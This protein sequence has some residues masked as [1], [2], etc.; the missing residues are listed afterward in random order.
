[1]SASITMTTRRTRATGSLILFG[2]AAGVAL[3]SG[4]IVRLFGG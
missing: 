4:F 3:A 1:M 2:A